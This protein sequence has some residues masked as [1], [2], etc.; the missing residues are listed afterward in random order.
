MI[1]PQTFWIVIFIGDGIQDKKIIALTLQE[2][3][4]ENIVYVKAGANTA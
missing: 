3:N 1:I 4:F 2:N